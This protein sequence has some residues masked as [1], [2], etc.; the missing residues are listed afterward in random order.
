MIQPAAVNAQFGL[1][2]RRAADAGGAA[3]FEQ[4]NKMAAE[5]MASDEKKKGVGQALDLS[6][7]GDLGDIGELMKDLDPATL[8]ELMMEGMKDPQVQEMVS[9]ISL[10]FALCY[11]L[12]LT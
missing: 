7:L 12:I 5:R 6:N 9:L 8:Q 10:D 2:N 1:P 11:L 3:S 4:L